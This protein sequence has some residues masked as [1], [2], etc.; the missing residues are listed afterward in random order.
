M[1]KVA[2]IAE[3]SGSRQV[4]GFGRGVTWLK[5]EGVSM[6]T[7]FLPAWAEVLPAPLRPA[8]RPLLHSPDE[9]RKS[10]EAH[11]RTRLPLGQ[12]RALVGRAKVTAA[13]RGFQTLKP[14]SPPLLGPPAS[15]T[16]PIRSLPP[17]FRKRGR[18]TG[19]QVQSLT[20]SWV[21]GTR[22][23]QSGGAD[24]NLPSKLTGSRITSSSHRSR[25][26]SP[27]FNPGS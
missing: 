10:S 23:A 4:G 8:S 22:W 26:W 12:L 16:C 13:V 20:G 2:V 11:S 24:R 1:S 9:S 27:N 25:H 18:C 15:Q 19:W 7:P 14:L 6:L 17:P 21:L 3:A 5:R